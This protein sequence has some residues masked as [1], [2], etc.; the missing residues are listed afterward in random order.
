MT[1]HPHRWPVDAHVHFHVL[2]R[3]APTLD[4]AAAN[5]KAAGGRGEG[6]LGALLLAQAEGETVFESLQKEPQAGDWNL[7]PVSGEPESLIARR[8]RD[9]IAVICGRQLRTEEGLEVLGL[10][11]VT[12][13]R[14]GLSLAEALRTVRDAGALAVL[15]WGFGKWLGRRGAALATTLASNRPDQI[16]IG[17]NGG[18]LHA[19]PRPA[20]IDAAERSG[21]KVLPGSD[22]FP[23]AGDHRRVGAFG[24]HATTAPSVHSPWRELRASLLAADSPRPYGRGCGLL[25]FALNQAGIQVY[26]RL[27]SVPA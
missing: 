7:M 8:G 4:A 3:V 13:F 2:A 11:T 23:F 21:F 26:R 25:R 12:R 5:F 22:S 20:T 27:W 14:D 16:F 1:N 6:W 17:D 9:T 10:G 15:P 24:F 18:R 19:L